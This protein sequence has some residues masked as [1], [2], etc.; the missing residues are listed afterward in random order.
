MSAQLDSLDHLSAGLPAGMGS[1]SH[2]AVID[3]AEKAIGKTVEALAATLIAVEVAILLAGVVSR[4]WLHAPLVWGD[5]VASLLFLWLS[6]L[7]AVIAFRRGEHM[8]MT[9]LV[10]KLSPQKRALADT[11]AIVASLG[12]LVMQVPAALHYAHEEAAILTPAL[13]ISAAWRA[14]A[15]PV[16]LALMAVITLLRLLRQ[17]SGKQALGGLLAVQDAVQLDC[18][19]VLRPQG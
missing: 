8:R 16:G 11:L 15:L 18:E 13:E 3:F 14:S 12:F 1:R 10:S 6:V 4:Y 2:R 9:A 19:R 5:E 7:G 17:T